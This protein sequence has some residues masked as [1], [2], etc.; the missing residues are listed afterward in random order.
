MKK[1]G[2]GRQIF[3]Y[4]APF[5]ALA[6]FKIWASSGPSPE[7]LLIAAC[8]TLA[9]CAVTIILAYRW[10][11]PSYFDWAVALYL[12]LA[13]LLL[14]VWP[15]SAGHFLVRYAVTG[16][17]AC[18]FGAA[19]F[20]PLFGMSPF[21]YHYAKKVTPKEHW[22][23]PVFIRINRIMTHVWAGLFALCILLSLYPSL[24]TRALIP[25]ALILGF[26]LPFNLRFPDAY[27]KRLGLPSL[28]RQR[29]MAGERPAGKRTG[30]PSGTLP[31]TARDAIFNMPVV[32]NPG[33]AE[34]V[35]ALIGFLVT[36]ADPFEA[37]LDIR[38]GTCAL[39]EEPDR[40]PDLL[41]R[42]PAEIWLAIARG[43]RDGQEA[44]V[45]QEYTAEGNLGLLMRMGGFFGSVPPQDEPIHPSPQKEPPA[46]P[47][48]AAGTSS[49][50][51]S[52]NI[53]K[54]EDTMKVLALNSSPRKEGQSKSE[55][56]LRH[57]VEGMRQAGADVEVVDLRKKK[58]NNCIG[59]F[60]CWTKTPG[61]CVHNDDMTNELF[62]KWLGA[63]LV[64][65]A[66][67]LYH[68]LMTA[69]LKAFIERTL[70]LL[71]PFFVDRDGVTRHPLRQNPP[72]HV[73]LSVAGFPELSV[74][75]QLSAWAHFVFGT[76]G[77][78]AAEIYRPVA[79]ALPFFKEKAG[80]ILA[81]TEQAGRELVESGRVSEET[82]ARIQQDIVGD[83]DAWY[84]MGNLM[85]KTCIR[86]GIT[87]MEMGKKGL[88]PRPDSVESFMVIMPM[89][90]NPETAGDTRAILQFRF[91]GEVEGA[92]HLKIQGGSIEAVAGEAEKPDLTIDTPFEVWM[93]IMTG[94]ADGQQMFMEQKYRVNGDLSLL[95]RMNQIFGKKEG[96]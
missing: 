55:L 71:E 70:P 45:R 34:G 94:K 88:I 52:E 43:E 83:K 36:G 31:S 38:D 15:D 93:D 67:P 26:G 69:S 76:G 91:S 1:I 18:L 82:L 29:D 28:A 78:L 16:I 59:C 13:A 4:A 25:L 63:D 32:F 21:T 87:P 10:D 80:D 14:V 11:K 40:R 57:L 56:M 37:Y 86:E 39:R 33:A 23:N 41:I 60:T 17:Y 35:S 3:L 44:F 12:A 89:G 90:F 62:P 58:I 7:S 19:F 68:F 22:K 96:S 42:T 53:S 50:P 27:L 46:A 74:F 30:A 49:K 84:R 51:L 54:K 6:F 8:A 79:E 24:V 48:P 75:D 64:V 9:Y 65:Y 61:K 5:P 47:G 81:A 92:C 73:I 95:L 85:W 66:T 72:K 77:N 2:K 20:P